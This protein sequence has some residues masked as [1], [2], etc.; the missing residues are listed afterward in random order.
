MIN[1]T[2]TW[3]G[4]TLFVAIGLKILHSQSETQHL[5]FVLWPTSNFIEL[6]FSTQAYWNDGFHFHELPLQ[7]DKYYSGGNLFAISFLIVSASAPYYLFNTLKA[8]L[9]FT[10]TL[11]IAYCFTIAVNVVKFTITLI[12][13]ALRGSPLW[14]L[15]NPQVIRIE[16]LVIHLTAL[17][18]IYLLMKWCFVRL[19]RSVLN[20]STYHL[21]N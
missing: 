18:I 1:K 21:I 7:L 14:K 9:L 15:D 4:I 17:C 3:F 13:F 2:T 6:L 20:T 19:K 10:S 16:H 11:L 12:M 5:F 8:S